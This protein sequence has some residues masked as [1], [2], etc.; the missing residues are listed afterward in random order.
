MVLIYDCIEECNKC[1]GHCRSTTS[2][3]FKIHC[4]LQQMLKIHI[5]FLSES[6]SWTL[7][8]M[9]SSQQI[10][11]NL[12]AISMSTSF[13][14]VLLAAILTL[15]QSFMYI[16][17]CSDFPAAAISVSDL[18]LLLL[19]VRRSTSCHIDTRRHTSGSHTWGRGSGSPYR[20]GPDNHTDPGCC[21]TGSRSRR[22]PGSSWYWRKQQPPLFYHII[23][24]S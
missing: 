7:L 19:H 13:L 3:Y 1:Y 17:T 2:G 6:D 18:S 5:R 16:T 24:Y 9:N 14:C 20:T 10:F 21:P 8:L 15:V 4:L 22:T 23:E 12:W 11:N